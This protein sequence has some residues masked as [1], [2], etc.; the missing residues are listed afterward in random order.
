MFW[1]KDRDGDSTMQL[2]EMAGNPRLTGTD[3]A[4]STLAEI[5]T[6]AGRMPFKSHSSEK[7][8]D[9]PRARPTIIDPC[10]LDPTQPH[11]CH[12][13]RLHS[14]A[15]YYNVHWRVK[16]TKDFNIPNGLHFAVNVKYNTEPDISG[17][18]DVIMPPHRLNILVKNQWYNLMLEEKVYIQPHDGVAE[19]QVLLCNNENTRRDEYLGF[20]IE[21][22][23]LRPITLPAES[24][25]GVR[26]FIVQ[27]AGIPNYSIDTMKSLPTTVDNS[28][29]P[30]TIPVSRLVHTKASRY[31]ATLSV[32]EDTAWIR[33]W[34]MSIVRNP[35]NPPRNFSKL[36]KTSATAIIHHSGIGKLPIGIAISPLGDQ[37]AVFQEPRIGE[38]QEGNVVERAAFP[39]KLFNNPLVRQETLVV[40][41]DSP[42]SSNMD[43]TKKHSPDNS[44]QFYDRNG[45]YN[46]V[47]TPGTPSDGILLQEVNYTHDLLDSFIGFG[48]F[49]SESKKTEEEKK[50]ETADA[51]D[52]VID[53][54]DNG[55]TAKS[56]KTIKSCMFVACSGLYLDVYT[57]SPEKKWERS[58][59]ITLTDLLPTLSRRIT[60][61]MMMDS[62]GSDTFMWLEDN[63]RSCTIW[64][65]M[66]GA[67]IS[68][69]SSI[70]NAR[71]KGPTFRGHS[72]MAISPHESIV[73]LA[74]VD[75][76]LT[77]YF[78]R[79]GMA[80][81]DR[82]FPGYKIEYVGF[83]GQDDQLCVILRNSVTFELTAKILDTLQLKSEFDI[84]QVPIPTIGSTALAF[85]SVKGFW[86]RGIVC[87]ADGTRVNCY[88]S[89]QPQ[90]GKVAKSSESVL[91]VE[92]TDVVYESLIDEQAQYRVV[93]AFHKELLPEGDGASYWVHRVELIEENLVV[94]T[95]K[96]VFS[97]IPE[98]WMRAMTSD[99]VHPENLLSAYFMP[100]G[101]RFA[102]VGMQTLQIWNLPTHELSKCT[103]QF[104][105]SQ[106][107][108]GSDLKPG[109]VAHKSRRV[110]DYYLETLSTTILVD[111]E[112]DNT[113]AEIKMNDKQ[114]KKVV[115]MPGP[116]TTGA[117][118]AIIH[119]FRSVHLLA[120]AYTFACREGKRVARLG[121]QQNF[122]FEDH[123]GAIV[124]FAHEHINRM[125]SIGV[126]SPRKK[127]SSPNSGPKEKKNKKL[128]EEDLRSA[129]PPLYSR[130]G[131]SSIF[132]GV[133]LHANSNKRDEYD[134]VPKEFYEKNTHKDDGPGSNTNRSG[135]V[136][137][138]T[139]L[140][141]HAYLLDQNHEF[142]KGLL[143]TSNG[144]W[145]PREDIELNPIRRAIEARNGPLVEAFIE[146]CIKHAKKYHP[147]YLMPAVQCLTELSERYPAILGD[148]FRR[149]SYVPAHNYSY[150]AS[151]AIIANHQYRKTL[152]SYLA[153]WN[154]FKDVS[155]Y[156]KS[157]NINDYAKPVLH[158]RSQLPFRSANFFHVLNI[159][160]S[161]RESRHEKF[162]SKPEISEEEERRRNKAGEFSHKIYVSPFPKLSMYGPY[163]GWQGL[164][165]DPA[166]SAFSDIAGQDY[167]DSPAM[168][169]M[170]EFKWH[171]FGFYRW[172]RRFFLVL[173]FFILFVILTAKQ[174]AIF[175]GVPDKVFTLNDAESRYMSDWRPVFWTTI[176]FGCVLLLLELLQF[177]AGPG[178][179][180][181]SPY[182]YFDLAAYTLPIIGCGMFLST[183]HGTIDG[184]K[185]LGMYDVGPH[186]IWVMSF[187]VLALYL[188][189]LFELR[190]VRQL[191]VVVNII[192]NITRR[193]VWFL[194][195]FGL[196]LLAF[197]HALLHLLH[198]GQGNVESLMNDAFNESKGEG[199]LAWLKQWSEVIAE[200]E[201]I[202]M[203][204]SDRQNCNYFP[205]YIYYGASEQEAELY[206][207]KYYIASK[208]NLS[209]ENRFLI[210]TVST[211]HNA[212]QLSQRAVLRDIQT[213][214]HE[215]DKLRQTQ[216]EF[217]QDMARLVELMA[218]Y[219][220]QTA[221]TGDTG[222]EVASPIEQTTSPA[223]QQLT[224]VS[225]A[226][227]E[228]PTTPSSA[229][230]PRPAGRRLP[231]PTARVKPSEGAIDVN[232]RVRP[233]QE[234]IGSDARMSAPQSAE[235][236]DEEAESIDPYDDLP[237]GDA[238][239]SA[240]GSD[241]YSA[242]IVSSPPGAA[243]PGPA[244][245]A[246]PRPPM[247]APAPPSPPPLPP[248]K[249]S[250]APAPKPP[251]P[252]AAP[253]PAP[254]MSSTGPAPR[255]SPAPGGSA[256]PVPPSQ[257]PVPARQTS[258]SSLPELPSQT[259]SS[260]PLASSQQTMPTPT[261]LNPPPILQ[262]GAAPSPFGKL[263]AHGRVSR[264]ST[265]PALL[266]HMLESKIAHTHVDSP[267]SY[268][269]GVHFSSPA[270]APQSTSSMLSQLPGSVYYPE[271]GPSSGFPRYKIVDMP[272]QEAA[273]K[274]KTSQSSLKQRLQKKL[275]AVHTLDDALQGHHH[276]ENTASN[277]TYVV[278]VRRSQSEYEDEDDD[279]EDEDE[280]SSKSSKNRKGGR[281]VQMHHSRLARAHQPVRDEDDEYDDGGGAGEGPSSLASLVPEHEAP[282]RTQS[283][284]LLTGAEHERVPLNVH[285]PR[286]GPRQAGD[287]P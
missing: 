214:A 267:T 135:V 275:M 91:I 244:P 27:R 265:T 269:S 236:E 210:E 124:R 159:E 149:A 253:P 243:A 75:G 242:P 255:P 259:P 57:V 6:S 286:G 262:T 4:P 252:S 43:D 258:S 132:D 29:L 160:T 224:P 95:Q 163:Q 190:V 263:P 172:L 119:C 178:R 284:I 23:E 156:T 187:A 137:I 83:H 20:V 5:D 158:L 276:L 164:F 176:G 155:P 208:S 65:L 186:Q 30:L 221:T 249:Y 88:I 251:M 54:D 37:I 21:H 260:R 245:A 8:S 99:V 44:E 216:D 229:R 14:N 138:L 201:I 55:T 131:S 70:E 184:E 108:E 250:S 52:G 200:I 13:K 129:P 193:T 46:S 127:G 112:T 67:N 281:P 86:N 246:G 274:A 25:A 113:V 205:D 73:A 150:I 180:L 96:L 151:H 188:N 227:D 268:V 42:A 80:I 162:P 189:I 7:K 72:K 209:L 118:L 153:F 60:C 136:T 78:S 85:F 182:N 139:L 24:Q 32:S 282:H 185:G 2:Q 126:F 206:E 202:S 28:Y 148:M 121:L 110:R 50:V 97:F 237:G 266:Q 192:L 232:A 154:Y 181:R 41:I 122:T 68:H 143:N 103:L 81:D 183:K 147:A 115:P 69:I 247:S 264:P 215:M 152:K 105:W 239:N 285:P 270:T 240:P 195:I 106:P 38:W 61:K 256:M 171:K 82:K 226:Q 93:T 74:S 11:I 167:F 3:A 234:D 272:D 144:D 84:N 225:S 217:N 128:L 120:A 109:G 175:S 31:L 34:D 116:G 102:V 277:P 141:D 49:V 53:A 222:S 199:Q 204:P 191:G 33:V 261:P 79:T 228:E 62:I 9:S 26:N 198:T 63:G 248:L 100:C 35:L 166:R 94:R 212:T 194:L 235:I 76:S 16:A 169:A 145:I 254:P 64:D 157:S 220:A 89:Y 45:T 66:T 56:P 101:T 203:T 18:L 219:L 273:M 36:Y 271:A 107:R 179:Y 77:T 230:L 48:E 223:D 279:D 283:E 12:S 134:S 19:V 213:V 59:T 117:R 233:S 98:P 87:E 125:M 114:K 278:P 196:F 218:A 238:Q 92:P 130:T 133:V 123:A 165:G 173:V 111:T 22:V 174:T 1:K 211:E 10:S 58:H 280:G 142:V 231:L 15:G 39:F 47:N 177:R 170:L 207:S 71:F 104:F 140:M 161:M 197:T 90:S 40:N 146:Y 51:E 17:T 168:I 287:R 241:P 257:F